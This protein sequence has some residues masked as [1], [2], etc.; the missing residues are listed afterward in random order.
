MINLHLESLIIQEQ[1][2]V[3]IKKE[4][5]SNVKFQKNFQLIL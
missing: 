3:T 1:K 5:A 2:K 4:I